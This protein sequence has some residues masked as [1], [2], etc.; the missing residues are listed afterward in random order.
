MTRHGQ[1]QDTGDGSEGNNGDGGRHVP[2]VSTETLTSDGTSPRLVGIVHLWIFNVRILGYGARPNE[3]IPPGTVGD[4]EVIEASI[5]ARV[6][7][8][9]FHPGGRGNGYG[10]V[11]WPH[12]EYIPFDDPDWKDTTR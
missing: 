3:Y 12:W 10:L 4:L 9:R 5:D 6:L 7:N 8:A 11:M 1:H 2:A